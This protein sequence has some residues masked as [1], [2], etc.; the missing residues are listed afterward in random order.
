MA[1]VV[2]CGIPAAVTSLTRD[3]GCPLKKIDASAQIGDGGIALIHQLVNKMG[4]IWHERKTDAGIDGEIELRNP[5]T[6]EV[7]N[8]L[9]LVQ[10]KARRPPV[11]RRERPVLPFPLQAGRRR[12]LDERRRPGAAGL[13]PPA[14]RRGVVDARPGLVQRSRRTGPRAGSTSTSGTQRFD[15]DA[16][17]RLLNLADPHGRAH[18]PAAE[19]RE[20]TLTSNLLTVTI[21]DLV[22]RTPTPLQDPREV[23]ERQREAGGAVRHD[24]LL[25]RRPALLLA[26][27]AGHGAG[28]LRV[29]APPMRV[30]T[31]APGRPGRSPRGSA[32]SC[33]LLNVALRQD[34]TADC[35]WHNGR[36]FVYFRATDDLAPRKIRSASGR[37]R[38][39][40]NPK[41]KKNAPDRDQLLPA[42]RAGMAV[43]ARRRPVAVRADPDLPLHP[44]RVPGLAVPV[45]AAVGDQAARTQPRGLPPDPDV[46]RLPARPTRG[47]GPARGDPRLRRPADLHRRPGHR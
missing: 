33:S 34:V 10:S 3:E 16:A 9:I 24:F 6:G 47:P 38:L 7:A 29:R 22:Y 14:D 43:P 11:P 35:D 12:L 45:G 20:E 46:G 17:H 1:R 41:S 30:S 19:H 25:R 42:R 37:Q 4:F 5:V 15:A 44:R 13:L 36:K 40:F 26:A 39:V 28:Q 18:V 32:C 2:I 8:R 27:A 31:A 23:Y 21:P